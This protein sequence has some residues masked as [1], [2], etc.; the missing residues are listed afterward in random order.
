MSAGGLTP[1]QAWHVLRARRWL[2]INI[3]GGVVLL[4]LVGSL[5]WPKTYKGEASVVVDV[6]NP[7]PVTGNPTAAGMASAYLA[8]Q[9]DVITSHNVALKVVDR[10]RLNE[11]PAIIKQ[12][13]TK[14]G[15]A[16]SIRDWIANLLAANLE[17][18]PSRESSVIT[19]DYFARDG[20]VAAELAN[21]FADSYIQTDR[22]LKNDTARRQSGWFQEQIQGLR[23]A[24]ET[25]QQRLA[26]YQ[27]S[28]NVVVVAGSADRLDVENG[29]LAETTAQL[30]AAQAQLGD[31]Q[32]KLQ[33]MHQATDK[34][35]IEQLPDILGNQL[36]QSMKADL[37]RAEGRLADMGQRV[38][39][40]HPQYLSAAAEV[41]ELKRKLI[42][43]IAT[44][45]GSIRQTSEISQQRV[46]EL[47]R[48]L[49][50]QKARIIQL[51][52]QHDA[53]DVLNRDVQNAQHTY[54]A[55]IQRT[56]ALRLEGRN[57]Q[58]TIAM[59]DKAVAPIKSARPRILLNTALA[60]VLGGLLAVGAAFAAER[61]DRRVRTRFDLLQSTDM[62]V[63][64]EIPRLFI[65]TPKGA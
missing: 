32:A 48:A 40:N 44:A 16:G 7:D 1:F 8:T 37:T 34:Q 38:D 45:T 63:L 4:T 35:Q 50:Q 31:A 54:D 12:Y 60:V 57:D 53:I 2:M 29:R 23:T 49:D 59:L 6:M 58:S 3:F 52:Q 41:S 55:A 11:D 24:L 13:Q 17:V 61:L 47:Q 36:L 51:Q 64:A 18:I 15:G 46:R 25:S 10:L 33:Q 20:Q 26:D 22:E 43:E 65:A 14:T 19:I 21:G 27:R 30:V 56:D 5:L 9:V 39:R 28:N 42:S 62:A